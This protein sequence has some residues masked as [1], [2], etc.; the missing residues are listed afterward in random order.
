MGRNASAKPTTTKGISGTEN[1]SFGSGRTFGENEEY[2]NLGITFDILA[3][4]LE[5]G[6]GYE[7]R[8]R[9]AITVKAADRGEQILSFGSNPGRDEE[10]RAAQDHL[11][12]GGT[13]TNKRLRLKDGAYYINDGDR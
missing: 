5:P 8:D 11:K 2:A 3:I 13:I 7:G 1:F 10:L 9:W 12:N 6:R 4:V